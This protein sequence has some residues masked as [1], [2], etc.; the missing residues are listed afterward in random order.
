MIDALDVGMTPLAI[1][2]Q[3]WLCT[4]YLVGRE[5]PDLWATHNVTLGKLLLLI[6][7]VQD[8]YKSIFVRHYHSLAI[9][10]AEQTIQKY[11]DP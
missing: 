6:D 4:V 2:C 1:K 8:K 5:L 11:H 7:R 9:S 10:L 3:S